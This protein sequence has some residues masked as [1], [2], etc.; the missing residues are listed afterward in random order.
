LYAKK[1]GT[2]VVIFSRFFLANLPRGGTTHHNKA[3][4][5]WTVNVPFCDWSRC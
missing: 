1:Y 4:Y 3:S 5:W 2:K